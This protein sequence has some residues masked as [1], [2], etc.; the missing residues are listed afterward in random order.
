MFWSFDSWYVSCQPSQ[1]SSDGPEVEKRRRADV[2][3]RRG[4]GVARDGQPMG[5][6]PGQKRILR[7]WRIW[8]FKILEGLRV[9]SGCQPRTAAQNPPADDR[10]P[11][12]WFQKQPANQC[13]SFDRLHRNLTLQRPGIPAIGW[14]LLDPQLV[15]FRLD[16]GARNENYWQLGTHT[17]GEGEH[18]RKSM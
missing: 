3:L 4:N 6:G 7:V 10:R 13:R 5:K 2:R 18:G 1:V 11:G 9:V 12:G 14:A 15:V 16:S 17:E 8:C